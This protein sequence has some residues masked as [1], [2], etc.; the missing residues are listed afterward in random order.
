MRTY[1]SDHIPVIEIPDTDTENEVLPYNTFS[2][3]YEPVQDIYG[4]GNG[5]IW[6]TD[7]ETKATNELGHE[8]PVVGAQTADE[9]G[10]EAL[11]TVEPTQAD[12]VASAHSC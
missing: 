3:S 2:T 5:W 1:M 6:E 10:H 9:P 4:Y 8:A 11:A 7:D 12:S